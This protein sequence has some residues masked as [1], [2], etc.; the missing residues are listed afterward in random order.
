MNHFLIIVGSSPENEKEA[1]K[2]EKELKKMEKKDRE[3][4]KGFGGAGKAANLANKMSPKGQCKKG[5]ANAFTAQL[6]VCACP[7]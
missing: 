4:K 6:K 7:S 2:M 5:K 1:K 3:E